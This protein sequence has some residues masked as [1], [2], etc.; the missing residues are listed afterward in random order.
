MFAQYLFLARVQ[1]VPEERITHPRHA[2]AAI[3]QYITERCSFSYRVARDG[4]EAR[5]LENRLKAE[6]EPTLNP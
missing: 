3:H 4:A 2:K 5:A 1:F 6:L